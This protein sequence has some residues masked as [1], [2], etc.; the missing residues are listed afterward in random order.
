MHRRS[1]LQTAI[2]LPLLGMPLFA[3]AEQADFWQRVFSAMSPMLA[4]HAHNPEHRV[5]V[6]AQYRK[7]GSRRWQ[8]TGWQL[9]PGRWFSTASVAKLPMA[10]LACEKIAAHGLGL[11]ARI[12]FTQAPIGGEWPD[13]EP[14]FEVFARTLNRIFT[15]SEN[16]PFN[17]LYDFLGVDAM[18]ARLTALGY[19]SA[20]LISRMSAP[21]NDNA[22]TRAGAVQD[23]SG[24]VIFEF[25]ER[26]GTVRTF[27][28]GEAKT[29]LG[30]LSDD[31]VLIDGPHD[32]SKANFIALADSQQMLKAIVDPDSVPAAQRWAIPEAMR[33][34][35][36]Q[37]MARMPRQSVDPVYNPA[38]YYDG[39]ARFFMIGDSKADK[40]GALRLI[41]KSGEAYGFLT[42]VSFITQD[43]S[44]LELLLSANI[45]VNA[46]G[47]FNDDKYEYESIGYPFLAALGRAVWHTLNSRGHT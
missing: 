42:D 37:I 38:E 9:T 18:H 23:A 14:D 15:I 26:V 41:G 31:G 3:G 35:V 29:G 47:I 24:T 5:Q 34:Q 10:L 25:P 32:F 2:A 36:L 13:A 20:R 45:Y 4:A 16:P 28:L 19:P 12:G 44:D 6:L 1:F 21:V 8:K 17:R 11:D 43:G 33:E 46:D 30:F 39:Y 22:R 27:A 7:K 40:P